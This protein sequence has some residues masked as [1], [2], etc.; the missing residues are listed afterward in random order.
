VQELETV[1]ESSL[2]LT[3][4]ELSEGRT[5]LGRRGV[6]HAHGT[7]AQDIA[8]ISPLLRLFEITVALGA[9]IILS[10]IILVVGLIIWLDSGGPVLFFQDRVGKDGK[11][12]K[13]VKFRTLYADARQ[14]FPELYSYQYSESDIENLKFKIEDDPR[15]TR[16]GRWLRK[17]TL[18]E[19]PNF[20]N[21]LTG[22]MALVG[23]RPEIPE[24]VKYYKGDLKKKFSVRPGITGLAQVRGRGHL[25]FFET[26]QYDVEYVE[27][28]TFAGDIKILFETILKIFTHEGAY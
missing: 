15:V 7:E 26:A 17:S 8:S 22:E 24:M 9:L 23:P 14:R 10:P 2:G 11:L 27:T 21:V 3:N 13:F 18:D 28:R 6:S 16:A 12:F 20:W 19:L 5:L 4:M 25:K 1:A